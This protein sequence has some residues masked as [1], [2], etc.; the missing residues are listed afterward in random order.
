[1]KRVYAADIRPGDQIVDCF[2]VAAARL[3]PY[4]DE[5]K[6]HYLHLEL[7]DRSGQVEGRLWQ[8]GEAAAQWLTAGAVVRIKARADLY[9]D[10]IR[11]RV[12]SIEPAGDEAPDLAELLALPVV[13]VA[14][15]MAVVH[16][17][18]GQVHD[19]RLRG[20]LESFFGDSEFLEAFSLA[21]ADR[22][23]ELLGRTVELL[24]L[25]GPLR[26]L[27]EHLDHDLL[28]T[29]ILLHEAGLTVALRGESGVRAVAWLGV[30]A[31]SDQLL[32]ERLAQMPDLPA[33]L[34]L[35]L[36]QAIRAAE[37][38]GRTRIPEAATLVA[39]RNLHAAL[40]S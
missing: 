1:M 35:R 40:R 36:R 10:R 16:A 20:L 27:A 12:D 4:K 23:G 24:E 3:A 21:P 25:A 5:S 22:P 15:S 9:Q 11:L 30:A 33:D 17:A 26:T 18:I 29:A 34:A 39:L 31:L 19:L 14:E 28:T 2:R 38:P 6:G 8:G 13:D 37:E 7:A 32:V